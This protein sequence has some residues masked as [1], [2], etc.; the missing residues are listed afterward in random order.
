MM[1]FRSAATTTS[2]Y[3][4]LL[5]TTATFSLY[6][7][8]R[9]L[10]VAS[11][12]GQVF[13][14]EDIQNREL[15]MRLVYRLRF[16]ALVVATVVTLVVVLPLATYAFVLPGSGGYNQLRISWLS[17]IASSSTSSSSPISL[18]AVNEKLV[19]QLMDEIASSQAKRE[20]LEKEIEDI[21]RKAAEKR[22]KLEE[23]IQQYDKLVQT[24]E[25]QLDTVKSTINKKLDKLELA[26][27][28]K[29]G[30]GGGVNLPTGEGVAGGG[31]LNPLLLVAPLA[32]VA[33]GRAVLQK[34]DSVIEEQ[35]RIAEIREKIKKEEAKLEEARI[36]REKDSKTYQRVVV[37][38]CL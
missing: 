36:A 4:F 17:T 31:A 18:W 35:K 5:N 23:E 26:E 9:E 2:A 12:I 22:K 16:A 37:S 28:G 3:Q 34:R 1:S 33:V 21:Q 38:D 8:S 6:Y 20:A 29:I 7:Y 15:T 25:E 14:F 10:A 19:A 11:K 24:T 30:V 32:A 27:S 13:W